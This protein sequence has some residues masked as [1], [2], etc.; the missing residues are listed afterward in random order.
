MSY[1]ALNLVVKEFSMVLCCI[2][3]YSYSFALECEYRLLLTKCF[4][5]SDC[6]SQEKKCALMLMLLTISQALNRVPWFF[7]NDQASNYRAKSLY[8]PFLC[9]PPSQIL[10]PQTNHCTIG[11]STCCSGPS[12]F[13]DL[14]MDST[15]SLAFSFQN[16]LQVDLFHKDSPSSSEQWW[17]IPPT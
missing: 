14:Q 12:F 6:P 5:S 16:V 7:L 10:F 9:F 1:G 15:F 2:I 8:L 11:C 13:T 17:S 3:F 4:L